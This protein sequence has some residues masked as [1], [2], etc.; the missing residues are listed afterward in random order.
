VGTYD[1][2][3]EAPHAD[4]L[5]QPIAGDPEVDEEKLKS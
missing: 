1:S 3:P 5:I 2:H 4:P